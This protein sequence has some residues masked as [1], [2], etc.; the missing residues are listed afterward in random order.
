[1]TTINNS[2]RER[3][4]SRFGITHGPGKWDLFIALGENT[5]ENPHVVIFQIDE[6]MITVTTDARQAAS[7]MTKVEI[8]LNSLG[9]EDGSGQKWLF[10]GFNPHSHQNVQG[11]FNLNTRKGWIEFLQ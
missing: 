2:L 6:K 7:I 1:M 11:Y 8:C 3:L 10:E 9:R 4:T 5:F